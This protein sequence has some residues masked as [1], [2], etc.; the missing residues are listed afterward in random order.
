MFY[1]GD[2]EPNKLRGPQ[3]PLASHHAVISP[4]ILPLAKA[5]S[6]KQR[7]APLA[8]CRRLAPVREW[9]EIFEFPLQAK[10]LEGTPD[11]LK[12]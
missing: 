7:A 10:G 3:K 8:S 12:R 4:E 9:V 2:G 6:H 11:A 1:A 5:A